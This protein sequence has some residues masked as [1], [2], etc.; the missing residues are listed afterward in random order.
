MIMMFALE[1]KFYRCCEILF[2]MI[3]L[4]L[5]FLLAS[6]PI[7]TAPAA[8]SAVVVSYEQPMAKVWQPFWT[9]FR[10]AWL[11]TL[12]IGVFN[13]FSFYFGLSLWQTF[14]AREAMMV[15]FL[16][17]LFLLF[18]LSYNC[19]LYFMQEKTKQRHFFLFRDGFFWTVMNYHRTIGILFFT[20]VFYFLLF[21]WWPLF[22]YLIGLSG[23][24]YFYHK[25]LL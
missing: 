25:V 2:R 10:K 21:S 13:I 9:H 24:L 15:K 8:F 6:F 20:A 14:L 4:N 5:L 16:T 19:N 22:F 18:L 12:P 3:L 17:V 23:P 11:K 1:S 7:I